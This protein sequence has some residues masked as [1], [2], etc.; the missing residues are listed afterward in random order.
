MTCE[1]PP[2]SRAITQARYEPLAPESLPETVAR[3]GADVAAAAGA[4]AGAGAGAGAGP[5]WEGAAGIL[6]GSAGTFSTCP[7]PIT[8]AQWIVPRLAQYRTVQAFCLW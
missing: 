6:A 5:S 1:L 2:D 7:S 8:F 3:A 4:A